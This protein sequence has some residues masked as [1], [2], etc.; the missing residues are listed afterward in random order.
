MTDGDEGQLQL[1]V[2]ARQPLFAGGG[3]L[4]NYE[5]NRLGTEIARLDEA[6]TVQ[7]LVRR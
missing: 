3:I 5:T 4:A 7:D 6:A 1:E 2:E